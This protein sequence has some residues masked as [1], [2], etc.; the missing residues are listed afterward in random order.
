MKGKSNRSIGQAHPRDQGVL[1][2]RWMRLAE[3]RRDWALSFFRVGDISMPPPWTKQV[4]RWW[5]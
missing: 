4:G 1:F 5:S 3:A 2:Q